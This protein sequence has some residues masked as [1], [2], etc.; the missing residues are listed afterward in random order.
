MKRRISRGLIIG[1]CILGLGGISSGLAYVGS[2]INMYRHTVPCGKL[3]GFAG[4]LQAT[5]FI[6][7]GGCKVKI[8]GDGSCQDHAACN[9]SNPPSGSSDKGHCTTEVLSPGKNVCICS[10]K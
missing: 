10:A 6:P 2:T 5:H 4:L 3:P 1:V 8:G 7:S 9:I